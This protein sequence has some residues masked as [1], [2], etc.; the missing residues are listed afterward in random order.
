M[1]KIYWFEEIDSNDSAHIGEKGVRLAELKNNGVL[2][3]DGFVISKDAF[4]EFIKENN[5]KQKAKH[6]L[7]TVNLENPESL[8]QVSTHIYD[9]FHKGNISSELKMEIFN[10]Y[11]KLGG[12]FN[13]IYVYVIPSGNFHAYNHKKNIHDEVKGEASLIHSIKDYWASNFSELNILNS[14]NED[15]FTKSL[16]IQ[17]VVEPEKSG[18]IYTIDP[19]NYDKEKIILKSMLGHYHDTVNLAT[20]PD[21]YVLNKKD[22]RLI[23]KRE[24][25]QKIHTKKVGDTKKSLKVSKN[26]HSKKKLNEKEIEKLIEQAKLTEKLSY[27]PQ[28]IDWVA[29]GINIYLIHTKPLTHT[30]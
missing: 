7:S 25:E 4:D 16:I 23:E 21:L 5:L 18:K 14:N 17:K 30:N 26:Q 15:N 27:F 28:E 2:I 9:Y 19:E 10:A 11:S 22:G 3:P 8:K 12:K 6:L 1:K 13:D 20:L 29:E 24:T